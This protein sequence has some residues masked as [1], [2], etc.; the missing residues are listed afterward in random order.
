MRA[1]A[2]SL[3]PL[4]CA[5]WWGGPSCEAIV[6]APRRLG[7]VVVQPAEVV[8]GLRGWEDAFEGILPESRTPYVFFELEKIIRIMLRQS[9]MALEILAAPTASASLAHGFDPRQLAR[10]LTTSDILT[11]YLD[12]PVARD[13]SM[14]RPLLT[15]A[16]L[17]SNLTFSLS[18]TTLLTHLEEVT[19]DPL[20]RTLAKKSPD[21]DA[22]TR[23]DA[24]ARALVRAAIA[25][26]SSAN[27][28]PPKPIGYDDANA[29]LIRWRLQ[30]SNT[31][32]A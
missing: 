17:A 13:L 1:L 11:S 20:W 5:A 16:L 23:A 10:L 26:P 7:G 15:A 30:V 28:L 31:S 32:P 2:P 22:I 14:L 9:P 12:L 18:L 3:P 24:G 4:L 8:L 29:L 19:E 21:V 6:N 27:S 25:A